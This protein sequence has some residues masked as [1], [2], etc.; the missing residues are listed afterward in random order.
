MICEL[1]EKQHLRMEAMFDRVLT[2]TGEAF[3]AQAYGKDGTAI[4]P[5][6]YARLQ[7]AKVFLAICTAGR[8]TPKSSDIPKPYVP[9][10]SD[11]KALVEK[12]RPELARR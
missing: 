12:S 4:G 7:A 8:P 9:M 5:D 11:F 6:H 1:V 3:D 10:W 2:V